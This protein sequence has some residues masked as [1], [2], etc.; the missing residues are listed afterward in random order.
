MHDLLT[1]MSK[2]RDGDLCIADFSVCAH[3]VSAYA[4]FAHSPVILDCID[5]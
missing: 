4:E 3:K 2:N 5:T 1:N